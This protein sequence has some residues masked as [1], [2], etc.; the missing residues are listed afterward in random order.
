MCKRY[1][2]ISHTENTENRNSISQIIC[3]RSPSHEILTSI[4]DVLICI[5]NRLLPLP[6]ARTW[7]LQC[8]DCTWKVHLSTLQRKV[9]IRRNTLQ[10]LDAAKRV[11][12]LQFV[13]IKPKLSDIWVIMLAS[14]KDIK[15]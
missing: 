7:V 5:D 12:P 3:L 13:A 11:L 15:C 6:A 10:T 8:W 9:L 2:H 1:F 14:L 4:N